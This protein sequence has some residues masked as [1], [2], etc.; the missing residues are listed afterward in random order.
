MFTDFSD[1]QCVLHVL[2]STLSFIFTCSFLPA[3]FIKTQNIKFSPT[4]SHFVSVSNLVPCTLILNTLQGYPLRTD[5]VI[6]THRTS[7]IIQPWL[8]LLFRGSNA[9]GGIQT[10]REHP[11]P[12]ICTLGLCKGKNSHDIKAEVWFQIIGRAC[13]E[14][15][16]RFLA[17]CLAVGTPSSRLLPQ[18]LTVPQLVQKFPAFY[19]TRMFITAFTKPATC[20]YFEPGQSS[21]C[22][23]SHIMKI[24]F[25]II[26]PSMP[27]V[28]QVASFS[29]VSPPNP[30]MQLPSPSYVLNG[31]PISFFFIWSP[32]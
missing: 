9:G 24:H 23:P 1:V 17:W 16:V 11:H 2:S 12:H 19:W 20:A 4:S 26:L 14:T 29:Q 22:S 27:R 15:C 30:C 6:H 18:K 31:L 32:G 25:N 21:P 3:E 5:H 8:V 28:F 13:M 10:V 7:R